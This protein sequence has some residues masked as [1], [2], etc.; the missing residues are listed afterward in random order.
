VVGLVTNIATTGDI[1][2]YN[3][4][5][6]SVVSTLSY[7]GAGSSTPTKQLSASLTLPASEKMY[8]IRIRVTGGTPPTDKVFAMWAGFQIDNTF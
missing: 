8:E 2:L 3:L 4:T 5:D 6:A 7:T 1:Q